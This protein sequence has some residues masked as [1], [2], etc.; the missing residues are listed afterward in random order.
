MLKRTIT[1][2][3]ITI[4]TCVF[5]H[6]SHI[7]QV[8]IWGCVIIVSLAVCEVYNAAGIGNDI[9]KF[10]PGVLV[11]IALFVIPIPY[12]SNLLMVILP[13]AIVFFAFVMGRQDM[14]RFDN[15][16][17]VFLLAIL[18]ALLLRA[19]PQLRYIE[20]GL[21]YLT[22]AVIACFATDV[23]AYMVG[24][25]LG[26]H[27][28]LPKVSPNKTKEGAA[29]GIAA[30]TLVLLIYGYV[31]KESVECSINWLR[32]FFY[33]VSASVIG[34]FGDLSMSVV[35]RVCGVK[36]FGNIFPGHG[37]ILDRLD[38]HIFAVAFTLLFCSVT[39]G[40]IQ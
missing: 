29:A 40:F 27:K 37:G 22:G 24:S 7:P 11:A 9:K 17:K 28:L 10:L 16:H 4:C 35:K 30:A 1:G 18:I 14:F 21:Y 19:M 5:L 23:A 36:D 31:L 38:S 25:K 2:A 39:G 8:M 12:Y 6:Y 34:Q 32:L 20:N 15:S 33:A 26:R 13:A 3:I